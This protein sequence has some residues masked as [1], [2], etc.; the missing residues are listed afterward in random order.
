MRYALEPCHAMR[1]VWIAVVALGF[2]LTGLSVACQPAA[3]PAPTPTSVDAFAVVRAT[4][5][6]A[7]QSGKT[8]LDRGEWLQACVD[9]DRASTND[10]DNRAEIE[11]AL[12]QALAHCLTPPPQPTSASTPLPLPTIIV[13]TIAAATAPPSAAT[14]S[15]TP[16]PLVTWTDPQGRFSIGAPADW[17]RVDAPQS[18]FGSSIVEFRDT[19]GQ[20][21]CDVSVDANAHAVSPEVYAASTELAMQQQVPGYASE[22]VQPGTA[23]G[24]PSLRRVF[25][26]TQRDASGQDRQAR[27]FQVTIVKGNT[28][29]IISGSSPAPQFQKY[30]ETFDRIVESFRFS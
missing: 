20:I 26:F 24:S 3:A 15:A 22:Q 11:Q 10:P 5:E 29:Y 2:G 25:T 8:H 17:V 1:R 7:Y 21:E 19:T 30:S 6:A 14:P 12:E 27:G 16:G 23:A 28:P 18:F 13:P 9:L 4:S